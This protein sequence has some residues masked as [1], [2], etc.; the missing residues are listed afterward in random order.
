MFPGAYRRRVEPRV[1]IDV[2]GVPELRTLTTTP[3][4]TLGGNVTLREAMEFFNVLSAQD[5]EYAYTRQISEH[6]DLIANV[7]VRNIGTIAGNL[8]LKHEHREFDSDMFL[9]LETV[10]ASLIIKA[11]KG[12]DVTKSPAEFLDY[13]MNQKVLYQIVVPPYDNTYVFK[14]YKIHASQSE[15]YLKG[16][17][18]FSQETLTGVMNLLEQELQPD[19]ILPDASPQYRK[20]LAEALYYKLYREKFSCSC[21]GSTKFSSSLVVPTRLNLTPF[22]SPLFHRRI[23]EASEI[24]PGTSG[25]VAMNSFIRNSKALLDLIYWEDRNDQFLLQ[26]S[27]SRVK[28]KYLSGGEL[29]TRPPSSGVQQFQTDS[30]QWPLNQP[31]PKIEALVQCSG[32]AEY[33]N[34][35]PPIPGQLFAAFVLTTEAVGNIVDIDPSPALVSAADI[36]ACSIGRTPLSRV[37]GEANLYLLFCSGKVLYEGQPVGIIVAVTR[38]LANKAANNVRIQYTNVEKP[39]IQLRDIVGAENGTRVDLGQASGANIDKGVTVPI[40]VTHVVKGSFC[41]SRQYHFTME[42]QTC[43]TVPTENG[44]NVFSSTQW[45]D[46]VQGAIAQILA[47]PENSVVVSVRRVGGAYGSKISRANFTAAASALAANILNKPVRMILR[48]ET[49][50]RAVGFR[51]EALNKYE[52]STWTAVQSSKE[53]PKGMSGFESRLG[54]LRVGVDDVGNIKYLKSDFFCNIGSSNNYSYALLVPVL[55]P[56]CY[57]SLDWSVLNHDVMTHMAAQVPTRAPATFQCIA[58]IEY[59]MQHIA[60][61]VQKDPVQ[62]RIN[63]IAA[64]HPVMSMIDELK[65]SSQ[66]DERLKD[67]EA[68]NKVNRWKKKGISLVP[69]QHNL[70]LIGTFRALVSIYAADGT[71]TVQHA[72]TE[73]GQGINTK[74]AQVCAHTLGIPLDLV[75]IQPSNSVVAAN[76]DSTAGSVTSDTCCYATIECCKILLAR[77]EPVRLTLVDPTWLTLVSTAKAMEVDL[78]AV[79]MFSSQ[80]DGKPYAVY[81]VCVSEVEIDV[82]TG[83]QQVKRVDILEDAGQSISPLIDVGQVMGAFVMGMGVWTHEDIVYDPTGGAVLTNR[84]WNYYPPGMKDIPIDFRVTLKKD[85]PNPVGVAR[86]KGTGEPALCLAVSVFIALRNAINSARTDAGV[87]NG[88]Y[89]LVEVHLHLAGGKVENHFGKTTLSTPDRDSNLDLPVIGSLVPRE[90]TSD[91]GSDL[92]EL[93]YDT[94][95]VLILEQGL[96]SVFSPYLSSLLV[97][98]PDKSLPR[99]LRAETIAYSD[100]CAQSVEQVGDPVSIP[101]LYQVNRRQEVI[102]FVKALSTPVSLIEF[103]AEK[104]RTLLAHS[105]FVSNNRIFYLLTTTIHREKKH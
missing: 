28:S 10:G 89:D 67:I 46:N 83:Q 105:Y 48:M 35:H 1:Y 43:L 104:T 97:W 26:L 63:N 95:P 96:L 99:Q 42:T 12:S 55:F 72:G 31:V 51:P 2:S 49:N 90:W 23:L 6:I 94:K 40:G 34:D 84:T 39:V 77:L 82:L 75:S 45:M 85:S 5:Q 68:F 32:E 73:I 92:P 102:W 81:G 79:Y 50:M 20:G 4:V 69:M 76:G 3:K 38:R 33:V 25:P 52:A 70:L 87:A 14:T 60:N 47:I 24:E 58:S 57:T 9:L 44:L 59:I 62:V 78:T 103:P 86:S 27:G 53:G 54:L 29:L 22:R 7:S 30:S 41:N 15:N 18:V 74:V 64:V 61:V 16:K 36:L 17:S 91:N 100:N 98:C 66:Y 11:D 56:N 8:M 19:Y 21:V 101:R 93:F 37:G 65:T 71:V 80:R 13:D 88:W